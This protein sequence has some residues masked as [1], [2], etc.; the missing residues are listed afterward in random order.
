MISVDDWDPNALTSVMTETR[1][2]D[3]ES[4]AVGRSHHYEFA[5]HALRKAFYAHPNETLATLT[6]KQELPL[7]DLWR[8]VGR[9]GVAGGREALDP[10]DLSVT[11]VSFARDQACALV[12]LPRPSQDPE[13]YYVALVSTAS[14]FRY[15]TLERPALAETE[16]GVDFGLLGEWT[17]DG[18]H[19]DT[20]IEVAATVPG[21]AT[22]VRRYI[23]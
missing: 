1:T 22:A 15:F 2:V 17:A 23:A 18:T 7:I 9:A 20:M 5:H 14:T 10:R 13:A 21:F 12:T 4:A 3:E 6:A 8:R 19:L 16:A 11:L